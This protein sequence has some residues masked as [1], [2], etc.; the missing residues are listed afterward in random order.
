MSWYLETGEQSDV[1][2]STRVRVARNLK[3]IPFPARLSREE[4][5]RVTERVSEAFAKVCHKRGRKMLRL[6]MRALDR[7]HRQALAEHR[8]ISREMLADDRPGVLLL[9]D[10][11]RFGVL[12]NE[13]DHVRIVSMRAGLALQ[14]ALDD[15]LELA[16][17]LERDLGFAYDPRFGYLTS[18]P[19]NTGTGLRV[20]AMLHVPALCRLKMVTKLAKRLARA[21]YAVRGADGEGTEVLC[22]MI[23]ISNQVTLG[24]SEQQIA[25]GLAELVGDL[26]TSERGYRDELY[27]RDPMALEDECHRA[28]AIMGAA[29]RMSYTE[30]MQL[31]SSTR[32]GFYLGLLPEAEPDKIQ[33]LFVDVGEGVVQRAAGRLLL[34]QE[35]LE[36]RA[37][38]MRCILSGHKKDRNEDK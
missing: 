20:S 27:R 2:L 29:R 18:C 1:V 28:L 21:G 13:E 17:A 24:L 22:D 31:I 15:A 12:V 34:E 32:L 9:S 14:E 38:Q 16:A 10:D 19:T 11:E 25:D 3:D 26:A 8:L 6:D 36:A 5:D 37:D 7:V 4:A 33:R 30:A 35:L 23:Q